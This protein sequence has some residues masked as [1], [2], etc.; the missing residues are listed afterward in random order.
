M[1]GNYQVRFGGGSL[2]KQESIQRIESLLAGFLPYMDGVRLAMQDVVESN[3]AAQCIIVPNELDS[4]LRIHQHSLETLQAA[5]PGSVI[6]AIPSHVR[7]RELASVQ[8]TIWEYDPKS[9][10]IPVLEQLV[11]WITRSEESMLFDPPIEELVN[12]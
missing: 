12:A 1:M 9:P 4:R 8:K 5:Y 6:D 11:D 7:V 3:P 10:V 2:E